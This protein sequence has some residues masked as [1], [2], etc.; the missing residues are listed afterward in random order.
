MFSRLDHESKAVLFPKDWADGLKQILLNIYG[1][2]CIKDEKTFEIFGFS[3]PNEVLLIISY[4]GLDKFESPVT[5]FLSSDLTLKTATDK[6]M[7][8]MFDSAGVFFDSYFATEESEDEIWDDY[9]LDWQDA[10]FGSD[11]IFYKVTRENVML[12]MEANLILGDLA[13]E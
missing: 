6:I 3:Y 8:T 2:R 10:E 5:L 11:K 7:D 4:V 13:D 1:E 9:V 12:T